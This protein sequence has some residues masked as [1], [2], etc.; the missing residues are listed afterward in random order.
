MKVIALAVLLLA[1]TTSFAKDKKKKDADPTL[2]ETSD[3]L[4]RTLQ[5]YGGGIT[6]NS[7]W[8]GPQW[9]ATLS[10]VTLDTSCHLSYKHIIANAQGE[11]TASYS[12]DI[13]LGAVTDVQASIGN[14]DVWIY[15]TTGSVNGVVYDGNGTTP[16]N[17]KTDNHD[18][19]EVHTTPSS[20]PG[21]PVPDSPEQMAPRIVSAL[22]HAVDL[23]R[24]TYK[25]PVQQKEPF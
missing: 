2:Q 21:Q 24:E 8:T 12:A 19:I 10:N 14:V 22:N 25:S 15:V 16:G 13:A 7:D 11:T 5:S 23:C 1:A 4:V 9:I 3:W 20:Q 17:L 18:Q 6:P